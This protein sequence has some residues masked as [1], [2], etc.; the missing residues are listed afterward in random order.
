[1]IKIENGDIESIKGKEVF[2]VQFNKSSREM[3]ASVRKGRIRKAWKDDARKFPIFLLQIHLFEISRVSTDGT[4]MYEDELEPNVQTIPS[5]GFV[6]ETLEEAFLSMARNSASMAVTFL[7][8][9]EALLVRK[10][11]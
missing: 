4:F 11:S 2:I 8:Y 5:Y 10:D 3:L 1:M 9:Y 6:Y 7:R